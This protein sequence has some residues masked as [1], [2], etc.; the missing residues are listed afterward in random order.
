MES[1]VLNGGFFQFFFNSTGMLAD[2]AVVGAHRI[3]AEDVA[4]IIR[5][6]LNIFPDGR[7]ISD[8]A[9]RQDY[10]ERGELTE[11]LDALDDRF[12]RPGWPRSAIVTGCSR[13]RVRPAAPGGVLLPRLA[14]RA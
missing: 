7:L 5:A 1:E 9:A 2:E 6:A 14:P 11:V 4:S 13:G 12:S 10:M 8:N 3:G